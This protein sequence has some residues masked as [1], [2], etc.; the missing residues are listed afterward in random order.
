MTNG[1]V[2]ARD[3]RKPPPVGVYRISFIPDV[4]RN[5]V[6]LKTDNRLH[7]TQRFKLRIKMSYRDQSPHHSPNV[8]FGTQYH[9]EHHENIPSQLSYWLDIVSNVF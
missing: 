2:S 4:R 3:V 5:S 1:Q 7:S 9:I 6:K 8:T